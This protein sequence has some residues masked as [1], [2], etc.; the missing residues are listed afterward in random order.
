MIP[1]IS[2]LKIFNWL[3]NTEAYIILRDVYK[4]QVYPYGTPAAN[5]LASDPD[6]IFL[7][8]GPGDPE[9]AVEAIEDCLLY[10]SF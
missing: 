3:T 5:I 9:E 10:T 6:G 1:I 7:T 4:R 8:N 2:L